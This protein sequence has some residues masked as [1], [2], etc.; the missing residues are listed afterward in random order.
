M[1]S[2]RQDEGRRRIFDTRGLTCFRLEG[3]LVQDNFS[4]SLE[5]PEDQ[6][7]KASIAAALQSDAGEH[8]QHVEVRQV[9]QRGAHSSCVGILNRFQA[10]HEHVV[11]TPQWRGGAGPRR[12]LEA[13]PQGRL[14][15]RAFHLGEAFCRRQGQWSL[16]PFAEW[17][18]PET[19]L[20][21]RVA[22]RAQRPVRTC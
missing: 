7:V 15:Q 21:G 11:C 14:G 2:V 13:L 10:G 8:R 20:C 5:S 22:C 4:A 9:P 6:D 19:A 3:D 12:R 1:G 18:K 17:M 16:Y